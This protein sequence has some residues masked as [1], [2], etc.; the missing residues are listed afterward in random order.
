[1]DASSRVHRRPDPPGRFLV[2]APTKRRN[3]SADNSALS[4]PLSRWNIRR[5]TFISGACASAALFEWNPAYNRQKEKTVIGTQRLP[6]GFISV[7]SPVMTESMIVSPK[8]ALDLQLS[9]NIGSHP[10][11]VA[12]RKSPLRSDGEELR[13]STTV[14]YVHQESFAQDK[15]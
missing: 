15:L 7:G 6:T 4:Y 9:Q 8:I 13:G 3:M 12:C 5:R 1:M 14:N 2:A 10:F 11:R